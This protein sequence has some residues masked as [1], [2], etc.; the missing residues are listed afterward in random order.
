MD[1]GRK[2][3]VLIAAAILVAAS[4]EERRGPKRLP[5]Q[6]E[7]RIAHCE[8]HSR[9]GADMKKIDAAHPVGEG[10]RQ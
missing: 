8:R 2:R 7:D 10:I 4:L 3:G 6:S 5:P 9:G 1:E